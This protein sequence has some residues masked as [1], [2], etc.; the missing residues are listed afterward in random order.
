MALMSYAQAACAAVR[1][2]MKAD[3]AM[4]VVG[5]DVGRGG[6]FQQYNG[7]QQ[8]FGAA[9]VIDAPISEATI[10]GAGVGMAL[11]GLKPVVEM[12]VVDFALCAMDEIVNQ[13]AKARYMFGGQAR[14]PLVARLPI[15]LWSGSAAQHSQSLEAWFAHVP[16][17]VVVAPATP[18][19][20]YSLLS[21]AI[22][23]GD[24]VVYMEH[25]ELWGLQGE[26]S[27][28]Q[29]TLGRA[30]ILREGDD[31]TLV[32]WSRA[33][34]VALEAAGKA[35]RPVEVIDLRTLWPWD[36]ETVFASVMKTKKLLVVHE[37]VQAAGFGAEIAATVAEELQVP[38][39]RLGAPRIP[40]GY[41]KPLED[42][43]RVT[44]ERIARLLQ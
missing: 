42:E 25:K 1:E 13:A 23:C 40:V 30:R 36:R 43:A 34:H 24:P 17:L 26:V 33:V 5:E 41:S 16:G 19:D 35:K 2:A 10:L 31:I 4:V 15:G 20:N 37:A 39:K 29:G 14:V 22:D 18:Q 6:I 38:V 32:T 28:E 27:E 3:P 11:A 12:R 21:A 9:R 44:A 8:E 7:L